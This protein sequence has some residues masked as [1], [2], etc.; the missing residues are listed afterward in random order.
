MKQ[1]W[2]LTWCKHL[3]FQQ[4]LSSSQHLLRLPFALCFP[5]KIKLIG[6]SGWL[7]FGHKPQSASISPKRWYW[8]LIVGIED[9]S[10]DVSLLEE[11]TNFLCFTSAFYMLEMSISEFARPSLRGI[12]AQCGCIAALTQ[13]AEEPHHLSNLDWSS[14]TLY[15]C[16]EKWDSSQSLVIPAVMSCTMKV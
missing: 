3:L 6:D 12:R 7:C 13:G 11:W 8:S 2:T 4:A 15:C 5:K 16:E 9:D 14:R 1:S 10:A